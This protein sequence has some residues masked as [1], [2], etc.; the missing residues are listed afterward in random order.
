MTAPLL[1]VVGPTASGKTE[2]S[3]PEAEALGAE[4]VCVDSM[5]VYRGMDVG[6]AKPDAEARVR[7]RHHLLDLVDPA[8]PFSVHR[9]QRE[10]RTAIDAVRAG[11]HPVLVVS[12][13]GLYYRAVVDRLGFPRT[14][15]ATRALLEAEA[16]VVGPD[17][18]HRRLAELDPAAASRIEPPNVRR[19]VRAL[20]VAAITGRPFS[21][22]A[23]D[24]DRYPSETVRAAGVDCPRPVLAR[25]IERRVAAMVP[26]LLAETR[27]LMEG[28][29][30]AF[31]TSTQAIGYAE[32]VAF[33]EGVIGEDEMVA[34]TVRRTKALARRQMAW[35]HRD[36]RIRWFATG[37]GG[38]SEVVPELIEH[39]RSMSTQEVPA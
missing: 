37:D 11:G 15:P 13:G 26:G 4:I 20:E 18:L 6:T 1:A 5:L 30:V 22:F 8:E 3:D 23:K 29:F 17:A 28:G 27:A 32:A 12:G 36:P 25:R 2:A 9:L 21:D 24:W 31:L 14:E 39:L 34:R 35:L 7:V 33:L 10:A 19:T 38:A 16:R